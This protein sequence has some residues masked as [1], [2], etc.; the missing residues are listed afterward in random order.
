MMRGVPAAL[1]QTPRLP[2]VDVVRCVALL[3]MY[4]A[5]AAPTRG[6]LHVF[7]LSEYLT[8]PLFALLVGAGAQLGAAAPPRRRRVSLLVRAGVLVALGFALAQAEALIYIV[9]V[10]LGVLTLV[11]AALVRLP[12]PALP[13]VMAASWVL[14]PVLQTALQG[15]G[16]GHF[17]P[18]GILATGPAY[19][20]TSMILYAAIGILLVRWLGRQQLGTRQLVAG[21]AA[22]T[23]AVALLV[24]EQRGMVDLVPYS[25]TR[26]EILFDAVLVTGVTL[27]VWWCVDRMPA[28]LVA[29]VAAAGAMTLTLYAVQ[30][31]WL[32]A[33]VH[34][35]G[36]PTDDAWVNVVGLALVSLALPAVW[37]AMVP[38]EPW[39]RGPVE[40][41]VV[42]VVRTGAGRGVA[43]A[44]L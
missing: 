26:S 21:T 32:A 16:A 18:V 37:R 5:H 3:S 7:E 29:P 20:I 12:T 31:L 11:A 30:I 10:H 36:H 35:L 38:R 25:G 14:S 24:A 2:G 19:R 9:L 39:R 33:Y 34:A 23:V 4:V 13:V 42:A 22:L 27:V 1:D 6:P 15:Q 40:G 17:S 43:E 41:V 44:D 28:G 8:M